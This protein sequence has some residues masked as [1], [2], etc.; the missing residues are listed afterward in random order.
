MGK[1]IRT[2]R[3]F[4]RACLGRHDPPV[5]ATTVDLSL[6]RTNVGVVL[7]NRHGQVW[8]GRR[9]G[10]QGPHNWQFPQGG[11]DK[12]EDLLDAAKRELLEETGVSSVRYL[13]RTDGWITYNFP[14]GYGGSKAAKGWRGQKQVWFA[15]RFE[16]EDSEVDLTTHEQIE[17]DAWRWGDIAEAA[18]LVVPFKREAYVQVVA[19]LAQHGRF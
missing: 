17:F 19:C 6:Y 5:E 1:W 16:G 10:T 12:G 3:V 15:F 13:G 18:A 14:E 9:A 2:A 4:A 8:L 7:F 11:V